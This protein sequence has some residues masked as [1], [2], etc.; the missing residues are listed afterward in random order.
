MT[1]IC[2][3]A[4]MREIVEEF[5]L[6]ARF[7]VGRILITGEPGVGKAHLAAFIHQNSERHRRPFVVVDCITETAAPT[8]GGASF[9]RGRLPQAFRAAEGGTLFLREVGHLDAA[10]QADLMDMLDAEIGGE[11]GRASRMQIVC[12]AESTLFGRLAAGSFP[13]Q[14]YYR[15]NTMY[16]PIPPLRERREDVLALFRH[17]LAEEATRQRVSAPEVPDAWRH[18]I[19]HHPWPGNVRELR[20]VAESVVGDP[21]SPSILRLGRR[22]EPRGAGR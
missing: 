15:L 9:S 2:V 5:E 14:L 12:S 10:A 7:D 6:A 4:A 11:P 13:I 1:L 20:D 17:F 18:A 19:E 21:S 16:L 3:S 22:R 8:L